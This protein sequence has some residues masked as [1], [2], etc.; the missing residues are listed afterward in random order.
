MGGD[1]VFLFL[2]NRGRTTNRTLVNDASS[3]RNAFSTNKMESTNLGIGAKKDGS[4]NRRTTRDLGA[5]RDLEF[6]LADAACRRVLVSD[7]VL[8][9]NLRMLIDHGCE[10]AFCIGE[11]FLGVADQSFSLLAEVVDG[12]LDLGNG[13]CVVVHL[14][15]VIR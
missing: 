5:G 14:H 2:L 7:L 3:T 1:F 4:G 13:K 12:F 11:D 6:F 9:E 8:E 10:F 15:L